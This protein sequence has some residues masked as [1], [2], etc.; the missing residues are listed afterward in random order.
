MKPL[1]LAAFL[2]LTLAALPVPAQDSGDGE[3]FFNSA[4]IHLRE[5]RVDLA[6]TSF[7]RA[8]DANPKNPYFRKGLGQAYAARRDWKDAIK[9]F[10]EALE[11]NPYFVD[12]RNDLGTALILAGKRDEGKAEFV[13]AYGDATNP[14]PEISA[15]NLGQA[16]LEEKNYTEAIGWFRTAVGRNKAYP[17]PYLGLAEALVATERLDEAVVL[18]ETGV[19]EAPEDSGLRLALGQVYYRAGRFTDSRTAFEEA[20][21]MDPSGPVGAAAAAGL[22]ELPH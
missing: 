20:M 12:V 19:E 10:R 5:G 1:K 14:T 17:D 11:L 6:V 16:F 22:A 13:T 3:T 15:R 9:Q 4:V 18:L 21:R 7:E 2:A 8:V